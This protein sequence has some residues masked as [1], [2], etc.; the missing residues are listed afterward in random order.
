MVFKMKIPSEEEI[1]DKLEISGLIII[2]ALTLMGVN[3]IDI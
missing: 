1:K 3:G 2:F